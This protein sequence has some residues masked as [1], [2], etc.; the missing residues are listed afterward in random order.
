MLDARA[1]TGVVFADYLGAFPGA[2]KVKVSVNGTPTCPAKE[3]VSALATGFIDA[4]RTLTLF[5]NTTGQADTP[6]APTPAV[7][8]VPG[9]AAAVPVFLAAAGWSGPQSAAVGRV[10]VQQMLTRFA[11][12][13]LVQMNPSAGVGT[14]VGVLSPASNSA[15]DSMF[16][17]ALMGTLQAAFKKPVFCRE[18][19][20]SQGLNPQI[21]RSLKPFAQAYGVGLK[22][23]TATVSYTGTGLVPAGA[24]TVN[25]GRFL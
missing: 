24:S 14:G 6:G 1:L 3:Y 19:D 25:T 5:D 4:A 12:Q 22:T 11:E 9:A 2:V 17:A 20:V 8:Q 10:L 21:L 23:L 15:L 16:Q 13:A 7:L 18:F